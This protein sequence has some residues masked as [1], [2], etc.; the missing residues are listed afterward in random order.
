MATPSPQR[1]VASELD[2]IFACSICQAT[3][4]EIYEKP[5]SAHGLRDGHSPVD[6]LV[7]KLW[8]TDCAH[9]TCSKHLP[10]G[11]APFHPADQQPTAPCPL[12]QQTKDDSMPKRLFA[13]RGRKDYDAL[14]PKVWF[15]VPP[16]ALAT[17]TIE[18]EG[19][20]FQYMSLLRF[21]TQTHL[22]LRGT[23]KLL[24]E[25]L[26]GAEGFEKALNEATEEILRLRQDNDQLKGIEVAVKRWEARTPT[27]KHYLAGY[28]KL[29]T[30][31]KMLREKLRGVGYNVPEGQYAPPGENEARPPLSPEGAREI[32]QD[33][34]I[35]NDET[36]VAKYRGIYDK[37]QRE[38][39]T[40]ARIVHPGNGNQHAS[41]SVLGNSTTIERAT[42]RNDSSDALIV[43]AFKRKRMD[44][45]PELG[46]MDNRQYEVKPRIDSRDQMPPPPN[47]LSKV[48][49]ES[50]RKALVSQRGGYGYSTGQ[51]QRSPELQILDGRRWQNLVGPDRVQHDEHQMQ[52]R[53]ATSMQNL[54][55]RNRLQV[56]PLQ[57]L[58]HVKSDSRLRESARAGVTSPFKSPMR[59]L[60]RPPTSI[61]QYS[62]PQPHGASSHHTE[63]PSRNG[64]WIQD[65]RAS[66]RYEQVHPSQHASWAQPVHM[67]DQQSYS[68]GHHTA[69]Q[70]YFSPRN[71]P[72]LNRNDFSTAKPLT[73]VSYTSITSVLDPRTP[74]PKR[75][76]NVDMADSVTSPFFRSTCVDPV[77]SRI[78]PV[79]EP[80]ILRPALPDVAQAYSTAPAR[81]RF[82][83]PRSL[84]GLSFI[85]SPQNSN[86]MPIYENRAPISD[87][88]LTQPTVVYPS[89][90]ESQGFF[91]RP[92]SHRS[93]FSQRD[94]V[95]SS[96]KQWYGQKLQPLPSAMPSM[97]RSTGPSRSASRSS[98]RYP[99]DNALLFTG[100]KVGGAS[101]VSGRR[102]V[103]HQRSLASLNPPPRGIFSSYQGMRSVRR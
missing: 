36:V 41:P 52:D 101:S 27:I 103:T 2:V 92:D 66:P 97:M 16:I 37:Y 49:E 43:K 69:S 1:Q 10:G 62:F 20:R 4:S 21:S 56:L 19:L 76:I 48:Q 59:V 32:Q 12:C 78:R 91:T 67:N 44:S 53:S 51:T 38:S 98:S 94:A 7:T 85:N 30:E 9:L 60:D 64:P 72:I 89:P 87:P 17:S 40:S 25:T 75:I 3:L 15:Q 79:Q 58:R 100:T 14:L 35:L 93:S 80:Q 88:R 26:A 13:I 50:A 47:R 5:E 82:G 45:S 22:R 54:T 39:P 81:S 77:S 74:A 102:P 11:G 70:Q 28:T 18:M 34:G 65:P 55:V 84:N 31:N 29:C 46:R 24:E 86:N 33:L 6:R 83:E 90:R 73:G 99:G 61:Q 71:A 95:P 42:N 8:L 68:E 57:L 23:Q 63:G 96:P